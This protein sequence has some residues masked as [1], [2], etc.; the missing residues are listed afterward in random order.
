MKGSTVDRNILSKSEVANLKLVNENKEAEVDK[1]I[2]KY[3]GKV[4]KDKDLMEFEFKL[5]LNSTEG[6]VLLDILQ[7]DL[8]LLKEYFCTDYSFLLCV[9]TNDNLTS[10]V[11]IVPPHCMLSSNKMFI[12]CISIIDFLV[13]CDYKKLLEI[14]FRK[15]EQFIKMDDENVS[16][17]DPEKY[18]NRLYNF[19]EKTCLDL[20]VE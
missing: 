11:D 17:A 15:I 4:F 12:Y 19:I 6:K 8:K 16:A 14:K 7:H 5:K 1:L 10:K 9:Y 3:K 20:Q 18:G 2:E 13:P